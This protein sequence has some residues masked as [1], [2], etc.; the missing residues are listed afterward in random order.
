MSPINLSP[1]SSGSSSEGMSPPTKVPPKA[2]GGT[3]RGT[4]KDQL[5]TEYKETIRRL[6]MDEGKTLKEII[7]V[8]E[9]QHNFKASYVPL[10]YPLRLQS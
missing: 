4:A 7:D 8:M 2:G 5:W 10:Q 3:A 6:Y 9:M 1:I